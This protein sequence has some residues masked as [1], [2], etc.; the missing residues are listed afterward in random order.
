MKSLHSIDSETE[1]SDTSQPRVDTL[2]YIKCDICSYKCTIQAVYHQREKQFNVIS[3]TVSYGLQL[4]DKN[5]HTVS[6]TSKPLFYCSSPCSNLSLWL[7][8]TQSI[9]SN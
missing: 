7:T 1:S 3:A 6:M 2:K 9:V 4:K 5:S 8:N